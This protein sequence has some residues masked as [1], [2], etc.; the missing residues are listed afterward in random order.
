MVHAAGTL[1]TLYAFWLLLSGYF[2]PFLLSAGALCALA[3]LL[4]TR[5][6]GIIDREGHPLHLSF[7]AMLAYWPWLAKE[8][9]KSGWDV[10]LRILDPRLP[11]SPTMVRFK[12]SQQTDLG[13]RA[14]DRW[15]CYCN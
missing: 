7:R 10:S 1:V 9:V 2:T 14:R 15:R 12:P 8:I 4:F 5:R 11:I 13:H 3:V 6:M